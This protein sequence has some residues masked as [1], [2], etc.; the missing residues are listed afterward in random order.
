MKAFDITVAEEGYCDGVVKYRRAVYD[1]HETDK[2]IADKDAEIRRLKRALYKACTNWMINRQVAMA[3]YHLE[4]RA[5][6]FD[7]AIAKCRA[8]AEEYK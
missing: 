1:K 2:I 6:K 5:R 7:K 4:T 8:K 3:C